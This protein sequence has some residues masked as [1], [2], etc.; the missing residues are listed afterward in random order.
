MRVTEKV[1]V[2]TDKTVDIICDKC[3]YTLFNFVSHGSRYYK[4]FA[5][6]N[7][8][9][10]YLSEFFGDDTYLEFDI[11]EKCLWDFVQTFKNKDSVIK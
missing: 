7:N 8:T 11:C 10:G 1:T 5:L 3:G 2:E 6:I 9:F 4:E